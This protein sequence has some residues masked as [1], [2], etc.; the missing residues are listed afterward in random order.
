MYC[1]IFYVANILF[2]AFL[3][4]SD[5][6]RNNIVL[7]RDHCF[8]ELHCIV[9]LSVGRRPC[10]IHTFMFIDIY[11]MV[12]YLNAVCFGTLL[13]EDFCSALLH[14]CFQVLFHIGR[15][16]YVSFLFT[17]WNNFI[18]QSFLCN[19]QNTAKEKKKVSLQIF[20]IMCDTKFKS[21]KSGC[22]ASLI[23]FCM[24]N[25][26]KNKEN[27]KMLKYFK[28]RSVLVIDFFASEL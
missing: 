1:L 7:C 28:F 8:I 5:P 17:I 12:V 18:S 6:W 3:L 21:S 4:N 27:N 16:Y 23:S 19:V 15:A 20:R 10:F 22:I 25:S 9:P 2:C 14:K 13:V 24:N 11:F 26:N